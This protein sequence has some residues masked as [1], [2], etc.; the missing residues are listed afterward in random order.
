MRSILGLLFFLVS[1]P[2][3]GIPVQDIEMR[4]VSRTSPEWL[5][6]YLGISFPS[7]LSDQDVARIRQKLMT[8]DVFVR[9]D[10]TIVDARLVVDVE[11][12]WTTIPVIRGAYGGGTP[13]LVAG[14]Y[15]TH[16]LGRLVTLGAETK[17]YGS[18]S[19][20]L[21]LWAKLPRAGRGKDAAGIELWRDFRRRTY[22]DDVGNKTGVVGFNSSFLRIYHLFSLLDDLKDPLDPQIFQGG[23]EWLLRRDRSPSVET[24][25]ETMPDTGVHLPV[26]GRHAVENRLLASVVFDNMSVDDQLLEGL[27]L[28]AKSGMS[29]VSGV[30]DSGDSCYHEGEFFAFFRPQANLNLAAHGFA[31]IAGK[32]TAGGVFYLGGFDSVRGFPDGIRQGPFGAYVNF[33]AR[34]QIFS[35][36]WVKVAG[37][38]FTDAGIAGRDFR[39]AGR[40]FF[41][42]AGLGFRFAIP[43][44]HR[45]VLRVDYGWGWSEN[46]RTSGMS[47]GLNQFFQ[48]YKPL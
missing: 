25:L 46:V 3:L 16:G 7:E 2:A 23:F 20:G 26:S 14:V 35:A 21:T 27:R 4:G 40:D 32:P 37:V 18:A 6:S 28:I 34:S 44:V 47:L 31:Q 24:S 10:V 11:E 33:E 15:E 36:K 17:K 41:K 13:L 45:L 43:K 39:D 19:P 42:S 38:G 12:K 8:T 9:V 48:P 22:Y 29:R 5:K 1:F 30:T